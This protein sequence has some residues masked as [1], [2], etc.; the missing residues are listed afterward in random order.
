MVLANQLKIT[1]QADSTILYDASLIAK[2]TLQLFDS[3]YH[4]NSDNQQNNSTLRASMAAPKTGIGRAQVIYFDHEN[5]KM[6]LKHYYRGGL[7]ASIFK[8]KYLGFDVEKTRAFK[9]LR[10][11]AKMQQLGLP[12]PEAIAAHVEKHLFFYRADLKIGRAHV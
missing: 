2:P 1:K 4:I 6:V 5:L 12:V 3:D 10:L 7:M 8:D 9:E 11:L